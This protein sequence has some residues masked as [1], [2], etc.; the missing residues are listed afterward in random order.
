M[1]GVDMPD[2]VKDIGEALAKEMPDPQPG[3]FANLESGPDAIDPSLSDRYGRKF[4][5]ALHVVKV[6]GTPDLTNAGN[7]RLKPK[8]EQ[9][10]PGSAAPREKPVSQI[11]TGPS[12][13][14]TQIQAQAQYQATGQASAHM[15]FMVGVMLGGEE[16]Q[17]SDDE[18]IYLTGA[19]VQ[20]YEAKG[21][22]DMPPG[23]V[24][25]TALLSYALP[26]FSQPKTKTKIQKLMKWAKGKFSRRGKSGT[27]SDSGNDRKR[28]DNPDNGTKPGVS[29]SGNK[30]DSA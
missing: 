17:P 11:G 6:D 12:P 2:S 15:L 29:E 30:G 20:Y 26:R 19:F 4:D 18:K 1:K 5:P 22:K 9:G 28:Q 21:I 16:W 14:Q 7:L 3:A 10:E 24:L 8:N 13:V 25:A 27:Q 23:V